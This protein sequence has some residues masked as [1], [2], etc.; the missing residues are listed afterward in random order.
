MMRLW[1][2]SYTRAAPVASSVTISIVAHAVIVAAWVVVTLPPPNVA[3]DGI[4]NRVFYIPPPDRVPTQEG[5]V[6][7]VHY[8]RMAPKGPGTGEGPRGV[9]DTR[10]RVAAADTTIGDQARDSLTAQ[11]VPPTP[12]GDSVYS[13]LEVDTAVARMASSAAPAYPIKLLEAHIMGF[14]QAQYVVDTTGFADTSSFRVIRATNPEFIDA[15]RQALPYMRFSPAKI[16][17]S[18]VR[19][20][21]EQQFSFKISDSLVAAPVAKGKKP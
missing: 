5:S 7:A 10:L 18:K 3:Q 20:L 4:A 9:G 13:V 14:V 11:P 19:Q 16:G 8:I 2:K 21:V 15:V 1:V 12:T 17:P 6:E